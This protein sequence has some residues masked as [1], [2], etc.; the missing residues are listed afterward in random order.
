V[1]DK[2]NDD[3]IGCSITTEDFETFIARAAK[4]KTVW[5]VVIQGRV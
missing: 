1:A 4:S 2:D 3:F 5:E